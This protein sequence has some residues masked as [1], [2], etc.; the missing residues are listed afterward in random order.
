MK[1]LKTRR[2]IHDRIYQR[3]SLFVPY[4]TCIKPDNV[5]RGCFCVNNSS[6]IIFI[7][8]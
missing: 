6:N 4:I 5:Q 1:I 3:L 2:S 7:R 8:Q